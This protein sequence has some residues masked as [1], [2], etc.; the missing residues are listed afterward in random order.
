LKLPASKFDVG[1]PVA[2]Y[3]SAVKPAQIPARGII[4]DVQ[5]LPTTTDLLRGEDAVLN[6]V[7]QQLNATTSNF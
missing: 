2:A 7:L 1:L 3:Y 5:V 4:P 6:F